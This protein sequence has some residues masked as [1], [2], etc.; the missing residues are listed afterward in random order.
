MLWAG[1][2]KDNG[3]QDHENKTG[4]IRMLQQPMLAVKIFVPLSDM[5]IKIANRQFGDI[6]WH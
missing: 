6:Y 1:E 3:A 5:V 2:Y 4:I